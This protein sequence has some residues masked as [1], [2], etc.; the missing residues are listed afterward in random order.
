M[1]ARKGGIHLSLRVRLTRWRLEKER[2]CQDPISGTGRH[3][4][5]C[6]PRTESATD[7]LAAEWDQSSQG[8]P[9]NGRFAQRP[10]RS[11]GAVG[12]KAWRA[13]QAGGVRARRRSRAGRRGPVRPGPVVSVRYSAGQAPIGWGTGGMS[14]VWGE[15]H[16]RVGRRGG[17]TYGVP[18]F[19]PLPA[20]QSP[21]A[22]RTHTCLASR[23]R[24]LYCHHQG[25][26]QGMHACMQRSFQFPLAGAR[27]GAL[28]MIAAGVWGGRAV[29]P[30]LVGLA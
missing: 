30:G 4:R 13:G 3:K 29:E 18:L 7:V 12:K 5:F 11:E 20:Q 14:A 24:I 22:V 1:W 26:R 17:D 28:W 8:P 10:R 19:R 25:A 15:W 27:D 9:V 2:L 21:A 23:A 16:P 6:T